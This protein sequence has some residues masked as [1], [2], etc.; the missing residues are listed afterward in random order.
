MGTD[1]F[2]LSMY[3]V[4]LCNFTTFDLMFITTQVIFTSLPIII[5][6]LLE[7]DVSYKTSLV[8]PVVHG[9]N[10]NAKIMNP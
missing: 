2:T 3:N 5:V 6:G 9:Y 10:L 4:S 8:Y 1:A 7:Q